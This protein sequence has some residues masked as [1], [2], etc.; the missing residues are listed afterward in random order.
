MAQTTLIVDISHLTYRSESSPGE[1]LY[2]STNYPTKAVFG[3][4]S[5]INKVLNDRP[6]INKIYLAFDG[7]S[8]YRKELFPEYKANREHNPSD[9]RYAAY[10]EPDD[11]GWSRKDRIKFAINK[12]KEIAP[13]FAMHVAYNENMEGDDMGYNLAKQLYYN[14]DL[15]FMTDDKDWLQLINVFPKS[16]V[17]RAMANE[18]ITEKNFLQTQGVPPAWFVIQ[19]A[20]LGDKSDNINSV[21]P[22]CGEK[23][24]GLLLT[25]AIKRNINPESDSLWVQLQDVVRELELNKQLGRSKNL[26]KIYDYEHYQTFN[27][28]I[29]LVDFRKCPVSGVLQENLNEILRLDFAKAVDII[30]ALEFKALNKIVMPGSPWCRLI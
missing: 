2:T 14:S 9:K 26:V 27:R 12:I 3:I 15:I 6:N 20:L 24:I 19:K 11:H 21:L 4:L 29:K 28:N 30:K 8:K 23:A 25:E 13:A 10:I 17:Y 1:N 7:F 22:G 5:S 16:I 18:I